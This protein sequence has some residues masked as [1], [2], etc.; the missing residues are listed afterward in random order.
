MLGF[1]A[2]PRRNIRLECGPIITVIKGGEPDTAHPCVSLNEQKIISPQ[3]KD[4]S[5]PFPVSIMFVPFLS[6]SG[7]C[8]HPS[9]FPL[10]YTWT[11]FLCPPHPPIFS[12]RSLSLSSL[13]ICSP[14]LVSEI[15]LDMALQRKVLSQSS[16]K[17]ASHLQR[18]MKG[19]MDKTHKTG[20]VCSY[21]LRDII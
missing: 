8:C 16:T 1:R 20:K 10:F 7:P 15:V 5:S 3:G 21:V 17:V 9:L 4:T 13:S 11:L 19:P 2:E 18:I 6:P 12:T 14:D